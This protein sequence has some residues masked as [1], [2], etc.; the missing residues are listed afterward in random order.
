MPCS[1]HVKLDKDYEPA[2]SKVQVSHQLFCWSSVVQNSNKQQLIRIPVKLICILE[3]ILKRSPLTNRANADEEEEEEE[4]S[5]QASSSHCMITHLP[6]IS[7]CCLPHKQ[8]CTV[9]HICAISEKHGNTNNLLQTTSEPYIMD[10]YFVF[11]NC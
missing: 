1:Y 2:S 10:T 7:P 5:K 4:T 3:T 11:R 8:T 6:G 9:M